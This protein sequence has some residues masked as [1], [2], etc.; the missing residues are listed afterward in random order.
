MVDIFDRCKDR[1]LLHKAIQKT[2]ENRGTTIPESFF[3]VAQ[4]FNLKILKGAWGSVELST[5]VESFNSI[6]NKFLDVLSALEYKK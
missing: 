5:K 2:F 6:W 3:E 1:K 4:K